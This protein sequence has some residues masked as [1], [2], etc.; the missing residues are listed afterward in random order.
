MSTPT[1]NAPVASQ[2]QQRITVPGFA[3][4][5]ATK[6]GGR[7]EA[8]TSKVYDGGQLRPEVMAGTPNTTN[9]TVTKPYRPAVHAAQLEEL[10]R[11]GVGSHRVTL[12]VQ[13][14]DADLVAIGRPRTYPDALLVG[15]DWPEGDA[16]SSDAATFELEFAVPGLA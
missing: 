13:D 14:T 7:V 16:A 6:S 8:D 12:I 5:F 1:L 11:R 4:H 10:A 9:I 2:R 15:L 3:G